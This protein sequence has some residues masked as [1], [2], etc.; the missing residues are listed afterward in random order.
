[1]KIMR[2]KCCI[3]S[4]KIK[5]RKKCK[6]KVGDRNMRI[7]L[8]MRQVL[9]SRK[10]KHVRDQYIYHFRVEYPSLLSDVSKHT[11]VR[12]TKTFFLNYN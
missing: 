2:K 4:K 9:Q 7:V 6:K 10:Q 12:K 5:R 1:M 8:P 3:I 11:H